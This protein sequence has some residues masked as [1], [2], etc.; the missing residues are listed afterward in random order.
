MFLGCA[1]REGS[2][3]SWPR[4]RREDGTEGISKRQSTLGEL[5]SYCAEKYGEIWTIQ[6]CSWS[7]QAVASEYCS[8]CC[9]ALLT[10]FLPTNSSLFSY[11]R[12]SYGTLRYLK[13]LRRLDLRKFECF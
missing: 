3:A 4:L 9:T 6:C 10:Y 2:A 8:V 7:K 12:I 5:G 11:F 1:N 13:L